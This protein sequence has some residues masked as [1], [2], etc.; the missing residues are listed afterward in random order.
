MAVPPGFQAGNLYLGA[1][2]CR[3]LGVSY[4]AVRRLMAIAA[5][6]LALTLGVA[7]QPRGGGLGSIPGLPGGLPGTGVRGMGRG[8]FP[9]GRNRFGRGFWPWYGVG[10][11]D[12][13]EPYVEEVPQPPVIV[14]RELV[15][16]PAR[17]VQP[18][19]IEVPG[20]VEKARAE[21]AMPTV[22][23]WRN[24][25]RE[26][27]K[28]YAVIGSFLYDYS[29]PRAARRIPLDQL[30]LEASERANQQR[31]VQLLIPASPSEVT[32]RF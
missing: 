30:D 29:K 16:A 20:S 12:F 24:G 25:G 18:K 5:S 6:L 1:Y 11:A 22:L 14:E 3:R 28:Q 8:F 32:V 2:I 7:G 9:G 23:V 27:V 4:I 26:E 10:Y 21:A 31:G 17:S 15:P 13:D 19:L